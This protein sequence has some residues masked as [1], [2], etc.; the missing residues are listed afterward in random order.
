MATTR[1]TRADDLE[2]LRLWRGRVA[3][4]RWAVL[5]QTVGA[6]VVVVL[7]S[8]L[9][10]RQLE[11]AGPQLGLP[12][13]AVAL[14]LAPDRDRAAR[15]AQRGDLGQAGQDAAGDGQHLGLDDGAGDGAG[16]H[17][18]AADAVA[19][20]RVLLC[21]SVATLAAVL[22]PADLVATG[23]LRPAWVA[24]TAAFYVAFAVALAVE[25]PEP[26]SEVS[27]PAGS[28]PASTR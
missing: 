19:L 15:G 25:L 1:R 3:P 6:L 24:G 27:G 16:R 7:A 9:F 17:R 5:A 23:R 26:S 21:A 22:V 13:A 4:P 8:Q 11:W 20:R 14:L 2:A 28:S 12:P 18:G 10:V